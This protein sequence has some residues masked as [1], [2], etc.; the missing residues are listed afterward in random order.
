[1]KNLKKVGKKSQLDISEI[2]GE[3]FPGK[4]EEGISDAT[5]RKRSKN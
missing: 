2:G 4:I 1:M 5:D 3:D